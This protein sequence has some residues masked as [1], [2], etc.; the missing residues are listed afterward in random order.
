MT[1][2]ISISLALTAA[3]AIFAFAIF[4]SVFA[5]STG[6]GF[7]SLSIGDIDGQGGWTNAG[8]YDAAVTSSY[9]VEGFGTK[10]FRMSNYITSGAFDQVFSKSL[11]DEAGETSA[12]N[13]G[14]SGGVRQNHFEASFDFRT[15]QLSQQPNLII[16]ISPDRGDGARMSY[17]ALRDDPDGV[18]VIFYDYQ[19]R[20]PFGTSVGDSANGCSADD[21]FYSTDAATLDRAH[22]HNIKLTMDFID[23]PRNDVVKLYVDGALVHT[24][25]SW[26]DYFRYC[27]GNPT[28]TVDS[29]IFMARDNSPAVMVPDLGYLFDNVHLESSTVSPGPV[30]V[31]IAKYIDG[32]HADSVHALSLAFP[33]LASWSDAGFP[34][35][36]GSFSLSTTGFNNPNP[37][38]ATTADMTVGANY[39]IEED[40][41]GPNVGA[42]C[43]EGKS[44]ALDGYG[45]GDTELDAAG[46]TPT[47]TPPSLTSIATSKWVIVHNVTCPGTLIIK[48]V[49]VN[50]NGGV[51]TTTDFAFQINGGGSIPFDA[52]GENSF[53]VSAG[54]F[55]VVEDAT[56]TYTAVYSNDQNAS[57]DCNDLSITPGGTVTCTITNDDVAPPA[58]EPPANACNTPATVPPGFT[59]QNGTPGNDTVTIA[60]F[61]MFVGKGGNDVVSGPADGNYIVCTANGNDSI[62]LGN[63]DFTIDAGGGTNTIKTGD[64]D[65]YVSTG[66]AGDRITTGDGTQTIDAGN[67]NNVIETGDG[68]KHITTTNANDRITTGNGNDVI[69]AGGGINNVDSGDGDDTVVTGS[70]ND[71]IDG[72]PGTD[73]CDAGGGINSVINCE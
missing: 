46:M 21:D 2:R 67:G 45:W 28:R 63:G 33:M 49:V 61:T 7:E 26:E 23:G 29:L 52:S 9:G 55:S 5:D 30:N 56:S 64:G 1:K 41:T 14:F 59:L 53:S 72:G 54:L 25:T 70:S 15:M 31:T 12:E 58:P 60:P 50:D 20:T 39:S 8:G 35:G 16:S 48:K 73:S 47:S 34:D 65:G 40:L 51:A 18:H 44:F 11:T 10:S 43:S 6:S 17:V 19:D 27:E 13:G 57:A 37:Y 24:G 36:S 69:N 42:S 3:V 38:E 68:D 71:S 32:T 22:T 66:A 62:T 4:S